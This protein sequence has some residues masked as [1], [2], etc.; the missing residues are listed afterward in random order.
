M[1][2]DIYMDHSIDEEHDKLMDGSVPFSK[3]VK[4]VGITFI[5]IK[6]WQQNN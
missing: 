2:E 3:A 6:L 4:N 1:I 5:S